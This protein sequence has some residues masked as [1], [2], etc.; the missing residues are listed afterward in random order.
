MADSPPAAASPG[1]APA[2]PS[3]PP[4]NPRSRLTLFLLLILASIVG[5]GAFERW[6]LASDYQREQEAIAQ[7]REIKGAPIEGLANDW[8]GVFAPDQ[9]HLAQRVGGVYIPYEGKGPGYTQKIIEL[10]RHFSHCREVILSAGPVTG[11][12]F[13][14]PSPKRVLAPGETPPEQL[15]LDAIRAAFPGLQISGDEFLKK[16]EASTPADLTD[17]APDSASNADSTP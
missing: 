14:G 3:A 7:V 2:S 9:P 6:R 1:P 12:I 13:T 16:P 15:D 17:P 4:T 8:R 5:F 10:L 11:A